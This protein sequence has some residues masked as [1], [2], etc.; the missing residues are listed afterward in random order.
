MNH[1]EEQEFDLNFLAFDSSSDDSHI[2]LH[3]DFSM[4]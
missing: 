4:V 2:A 1:L 3:F